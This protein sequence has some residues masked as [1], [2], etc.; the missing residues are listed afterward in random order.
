MNNPQTA[1]PEFQG[2]HSGLTRQIIGLF[3]EVYNELGYGFNERVYENAMVIKLEKNAFSVTQQAPVK[4]YFEGQVVGEY[5]VDLMVNGLVL[6]ELKAARK[7]IGDHEAQLL[8]YLKATEIEVGLVLN[9]GPKAE[10]IRK[11]LDNDR[12]GSLSWTKPP[13]NP[14]PKNP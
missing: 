1:K 5:V 3:Y 13:S 14:Q 10:F 9:F 12:K 7:L 6:L 8:N 2:K 4:V 11:V